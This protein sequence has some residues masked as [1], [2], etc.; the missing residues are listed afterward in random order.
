MTELTLREAAR[1]GGKATL[2]NHGKDHFSKLGKLS[3]AKRKAKKNETISF[4][5]HTFKDILRETSEE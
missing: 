3:A 2:K 5:T 1:L 4:T